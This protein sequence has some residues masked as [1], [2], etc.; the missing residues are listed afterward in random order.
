[1]TVLLHKYLL[2]ITSN[3]FVGFH[4]GYT[5]YTM[6]FL[7]DPQW[8]RKFEKVQAKKTREIK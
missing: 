5:L 2:D 4:M 3:T 7:A 1:M 6:L 8:A